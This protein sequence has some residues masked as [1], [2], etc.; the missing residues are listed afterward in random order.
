[1]KLGIR[2]LYNQS[3]N[4][5]W[6]VAPKLIAGNSSDFPALLTALGVVRE[7]SGSIYNIYASTVS[8]LGIPD[9]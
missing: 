2:Y 6:S 1:M 5:I 3:L 8:R 9:R 4:S 7:K